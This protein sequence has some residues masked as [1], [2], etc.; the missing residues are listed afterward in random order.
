MIGITVCGVPK[1]VN[2]EYYCPYCTYRSFSIEDFAVGMC[3]DCVFRDDIPQQEGQTKE[4]TEVTINSEKKFTIDDVKAG[5]EVTVQQTF[6]VASVDKSEGVIHSKG[7]NG[8]TS[9]Q[10]RVAN[11][12]SF[13]GFELTTDLPKFEITSVKDAEPELPKNWPPRAGQV[14]RDNTG[15]EYFVLK[16]PGDGAKIFTVDDK[17]VST[18]DLAKKPGIRRVYS[19]GQT[20]Y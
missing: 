20:G 13:G 8:N 4:E 12:R 9:R 11:R 6:K 16:Q 19:T 18:S 15:A 10:F 5:Q 3:W 7:I 2:G 14:W 17:I 1:D